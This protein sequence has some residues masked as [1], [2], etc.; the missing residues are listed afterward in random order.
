MSGES[1]V[2]LMG[3][4]RLEPRI[5]EVATTIGA[6]GPFAVITAGWQ[7]REAEDE[8][9]R[10]HLDDTVF[11]LSL[12]AQAEAALGR[13]P[14]LAAAH[15]AR[16]ERLVHLQRVYRIRL[17]H[18]FAA[19]LDA[20][21][22]VAPPELRSEIDD[23]SI[24][25]IRALDEAHQAQ[26]TR[27]REEFDDVYE[28]MQRDAVRARAEAIREVVAPCKSICIAGGHVAVLKN[29]M[30]LL[31]VSD[32]LRGRTVFAWAAGAMVLTDRIVLFHD[33]APQGELLREVLDEGYG[34]VPDTVVFP[35]PERRLAFAN[36]ERTNHLV[37]RFAPARGVLLPTGSYMVFEG[38]KLTRSHGV[39]WIG[40]GDAS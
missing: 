2:V 22:Y 3:S 21:T 20:R 18:A 16:Q 15:R 36:R 4:Q 23:A 27:L 19:E 30:D 5:R 33:D 12:N 13:D 14:E 24:A 38:G 31:G 6:S 9:L 39:Q 7:E 25:A 10:A 28:P 8:E 29:R 1:S 17:K 34:L 40:E 37:Q 35:E 11:N 26:C 32:V